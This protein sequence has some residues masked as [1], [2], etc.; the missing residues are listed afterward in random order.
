M[1]ISPS[2]VFNWY[3]AVSHQGPSFQYIAPYDGQ[4]IE[5]M[6]NL[7]DPAVASISTSRIPFGFSPIHFV[8][9]LMKPSWA[10]S[11]GFHEHLCS[12]KHH[13]HAHEGFTSTL[14]TLY[15]SVFAFILFIFLFKDLGLASSQT[16]FWV[17]IL[18]L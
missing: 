3:W 18:G 9:V 17:L 6:E 1:S 4:Q 10:C 15:K 14:K 8:N 11:W 5:V 12:W 2:L 16:V 13:K 7:Y